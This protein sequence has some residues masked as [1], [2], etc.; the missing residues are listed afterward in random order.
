MLFIN[1]TDNL[2]GTP[3]TLRTEAL[4]VSMHKTNT[5]STVQAD[6]AEQLVTAQAAKLGVTPNQIF[7][8]E[9][10]R[11]R[12]ISPQVTLAQLQKLNQMLIAAQET[13]KA[14]TSQRIASGIGLNIT[15]A[16]TSRVIDHLIGPT[17]L[18]I[19]ARHLENSGKLEEL[20]QAINLGP[21]NGDVIWEKPETP[22][23]LLA[24]IIRWG[25]LTEHDKRRIRVA[26]PLREW[27]NNALKGHYETHPRLGGISAVCTG[28]AIA[29]GHEPTMMALGKLPPDIL[30]HLPKSTKVIGT[31]AQ[32]KTLADL[33]PESEFSGNFCVGVEYGALS[34]ELVLGSIEVDNQRV[35]LSSVPKIDVLI[36]GTASIKGF[37][38][39][40][41]ERFAEHSKSQDLLVLTGSQDLDSQESVNHYISRVKAAHDQGT[42]VALCYNETKFPEVEPIFWGEI[43]AKACVEFFA[44]NSFEA[45]GILERI[46][47]SAKFSNPLGLNAAQLARIDEV[48]QI[49][50][51]SPKFW[52]DGHES[53]E[54]L[55]ESALLLQEI[56]DIPLIRVRGMVNDVLVTAPNLDINCESV[57]TH[58]WASRSLG[59]I[60]VANPKGLIHSP[61]DVVTLTNVPDGTYV[62]ALYKV[63]TQLGDRPFKVGSLTE[64]CFAQLK[65]GRH[66]FSVPPIQFYIRAGGTQS[67]G[68]VM[69][70]T[71]AS[72]ECALALTMAWNANQA[73][74]K[75]S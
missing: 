75:N 41:P 72:A 23:Q 29:L 12:E 44:L 38:G 47:K 20:K 11:A 73:P 25:V 34:L 16:P 10:K 1:K 40:T 15:L 4:N 26:A 18:N 9:L 42:K 58:L 28:L 71:F 74:S 5:S 51:K 61:D 43:K 37:N 2:S 66:I 52:E 27:I 7:E 60:K 65:D 6:L 68:D 62:A 35:E 50:K 22:L 70:F 8:C 63:E 3:S 19:L 33:P 69:D 36:T 32:W 30:E 14:E 53:P 57:R 24:S 64:N 39:V 48:L 21:Q 31:E 13:F 49:A 46:H 59:T 54:W 55:C 17:A 56:L 45:K 67:A